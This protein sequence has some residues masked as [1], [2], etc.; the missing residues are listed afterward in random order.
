MKV[1]LR[2]GPKDGQEVEIPENNHGVQFPCN[3]RGPTK[4]EQEV[5]EQNGW[6]YSHPFFDCAMYW[7]VELDDTVAGFTGIF[8]RGNKLDEDEEKKVLAD[9]VNW[10]VYPVYSKELGSVSFV[11]IPSSDNECCFCWD[12]TA[13]EYQRIT[14]EQPDDQDVG[15]FSGGSGKEHQLYRLYP[16]AVLQAAGWK[17]EEEPIEVTVILEKS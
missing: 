11:G 6:D 4:E 5:C 14:G 7:R 17:S 10:P 9:I 12:V 15:R 16:G 13:A 3:P 1:K 2:G 8:R